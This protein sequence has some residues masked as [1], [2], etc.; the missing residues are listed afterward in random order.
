MSDDRQTL[1]RQQMRATS[2]EQVILNEMKRLGFWPNETDKPTLPEQL[3]TQETALNK[4]LRQLL[5]E[6]RLMKDRDRL[7]RKIRKERMKASREKQKAN[8]E[9]REAER[10]AKKQ[11]WQKQQETDIVY[12]GEE[13]SGGLNKI[14]NNTDLLS[15][16]GLPVFQSVEELATLLGVNISQLRFLAFNRKVSKVSH[17]KRFF[18]PK[19]SGGKR[20]IS[21][22]M[23][24]MKKVQYGVL[25]ELLYK[26]EVQDTAYGF[27]PNR[28]IVGNAE[29][30]VGQSV[31]MNM[32]LKNFFPTITYKRVKGLFKALGYAEKYATILA[33][34]CTEP[35]TDEVKMDG[36]RYFVA[37]GERHLPQG[38][39]TSPVI[40]NLICRTLD[41][42]ML[43]AAEKLGFTFTRYA[44]DCTF[45][46]A[47]A[48]KEN[49]G[50]M[51]WIA[52]KIIVE[53]G[54]IMHP[55]KLRIMHKGRHQEVTGI[56]VNEKLN[57]NRRDL[58]N[59]RALLFQI[60]RDGFEG[61]SWNNSPNLRDCIQGYANF[62]KMVHPEKG[63]V[64]KGQVRRILKK[65][66]L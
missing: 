16:L 8:R 25:N 4:E 31:V 1:L 23:P 40:T 49:V 3:I 19:K 38:A 32:D 13:V 27:V 52:K 12:L 24:L 2:R 53:E 36:E 46:C 11:A 62:V 51:L 66:S 18:M 15:Q 54:F 6:Q 43:G 42:R 55:D 65:Y 28:S 29:K 10:I 41:K 26:L 58:K 47:E 44:D 50:K 5:N 35:E 37:T 45:S 34:L 22:P 56:V 14:E 60:E 48:A 30:H 20:L 59:F 63:K 7:L 39:P 17:Y 64:L 57:V 33:L 21:A 61:K 9:K